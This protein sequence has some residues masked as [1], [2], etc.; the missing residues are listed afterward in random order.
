ME[1]RRIIVDSRYRTADS[2]SASDFHIDLPYAVNIPAG[3]QLFLDGVVLSNS[4]PVVGAGRDKV[5]V[6]EEVV[7]GGTFLRSITVPHG[8]YNATTLAS[9]VAVHLNAGTHLAGTY[10]TAVEHGIMTISND[11]DLPTQGK[12]RIFSR[13]AA[14]KA[15]LKDNLPGYVDENMMETLGIW[16]TPVLTDGTS[17]VHSGQSLTGHF[18]DLAPVKQAHIHSPGLGE[19]STL[20]LGGATD[21]VRRV[22]LARNPVQGEICVD[23]LSTALSAVHFDADTTLSRLHFRICDY[24]GALLP[25]SNHEISWEIIIQRP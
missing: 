6:Q 19:Q 18:L 13:S 3:S 16:E 24:T 22:L 17:Y 12:T 5:Y 2:P 8:S 15:Y 4:F 11:S 14:D 21:V 9:S 20:T 25:L 1:W 10:S 23:T 7:G